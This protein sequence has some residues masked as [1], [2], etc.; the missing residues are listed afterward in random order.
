MRIGI[1]G[2]G[3]MGKLFAREFGK[4]HEVGI[5]S[6]HAGGFKFFGSIEELFKWAEVIVVARSL[7]ETPRVLEKLA[8]LS[9]K[10]EGKVI[11]DISTFKRDVMGTYKRFP[12]GV[13]VCSVH[14]MF[15]AGAKSFEGMRFIVIPVEGREEDVNP[16]IKIFKEFNAEVFTADAK[17]HDDMMK[18]VIGLPYFIGIS[19]LS[20]VSEFGGIE[21]FGGT[22]FEYLTTYAKAL[23]NDSPEF[24]NEILELS[25]DKIEEFLRF[26]EKGEFD[27][28]KLREKF[29]HEIEEGYKRFYM[30]LNKE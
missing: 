17:T 25:R 15:G 21:N 23:L 18:A 9:E 20:F 5:Y 28:E 24:I 30:V 16:V 14:P 26:A 8:E 22:S 6:R 19:F 27:I 7:E 2:Y 13:K 4:K 3:K 29:E 1:V 11:F 12:E 10:S